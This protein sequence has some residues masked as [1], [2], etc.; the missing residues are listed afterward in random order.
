M[1]VYFDKFNTRFKKSNPLARLTSQSSK[2]LPFFA[3]SPRSVLD[4]KE[5]LI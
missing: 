2:V 1:A 4:Q 3:L 5:Q